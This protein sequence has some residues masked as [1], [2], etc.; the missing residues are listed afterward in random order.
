MALDTVAIDASEVNVPED[1]YEDSAKPI[2]ILV[3]VTGTSPLLCQSD[4]IIL[5]SFYLREE[6]RQ[7]TG[8]RRKTEA[9]YERIARI[10]FEAGLYVSDANPGW[11]PC[12]PSVNLFATIRDGARLHKMGTEVERALSFTDAFARLEYDGPRDAEALWNDGRF[13]YY[14]SV[15]VQRA[16]TMRCRPIFHRWSFQARG[17]LLT[18][19][20]NPADLAHVAREAGRYCGL[21]TWRR[22]GFGRFSVHV[23][24]EDARG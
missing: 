16:R 18:G 22:G 15:V 11:G 13:T 20:M 5:P 4:R 23:S 6:Y 17:T 21:G 14:K 1:A 10:E 19:R 7:F 3:S 8:K 24:V 9:D 12:I 2:P